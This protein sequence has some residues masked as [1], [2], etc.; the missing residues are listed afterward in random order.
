MARAAFLLGVLLMSGFTGG[1]ARAAVPAP[2]RGTATRSVVWAERGMVCAAQPLAVQAG[3]DMLRQGGSAVDAAIAVN[4]CLG[5]MEPTAN[6]LGGDLFAIVWDPRAKKLAGLNASGRAPLALTA[7]KVPAE[8]DGTIP[9]YSPYSWTVPGCADG[10]FEL[11][12]KYGRLP[13]RQVL[14]P[15]I[16]YAEEGFPLS[17]VIASDWERSLA[18]F[19]DKPGFAEVFM[20]G[21]RA[22]REGERFRNPA[23]AKT[24]RLLAEKGRDAYYRGPIAEAVVRFSQANGGF[25]ALED[26]SRHRS[27]WDEPISTDYRGYTVWELPPNTQ[28]LAALQMLNLLE[29]FDLQAMGRE[30]AD[31]WHV[32][33]E[34]KKLAFADRARYYADPEF[35]KIPL[36]DLL[37]K[38]YA[39][40]RAAAIDM[41]RAASADA[42]GEVSALNQKETT[43]L[44][45]ADGDGMM[46][47]LIQSNYTGFGSGYVVPEV[48]FGLQD[49]G[50]LFSLQKGHPNRLEP[51]KRPF[52]TI[53]PAFL[54]KDGRPLMAFGLM[55]GDMQPQ[56][57]VQVVV[58]LVDFGMN[59]QEAGDAIRMHH[60]GSTEPTGTVMA[61]G[62]VLHIEDGLPAAAI[63]ELARRGHRMESEAVGAYG[64][65]QAIWRDPATGFYLGATEKRKD[66]C[67]QGF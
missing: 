57:H 65:Y 16:R 50:G 14:A 49:R 37:S 24:L 62:G 34:A 45:A 8:A 40:R 67:A 6:G 48:G 31:F 33:T 20:P 9:L 23:L 47:S 35:A 27:T 5:L 28:G 64:G 22:P 66:G 1:E 11:H 39:R 26:F 30:S 51:G 38:D 56:G 53:I 12:A 21:G 41:K 42:P 3:V 32:L 54:T 13:M 58:N 15:A 61:D 36:A 4:A 2:G 63:E 52:Q 7:E 55:G 19:R 18:R 60:T 25:F 17:P 29:G 44:C 10:W 43:Y 46:V 59:L